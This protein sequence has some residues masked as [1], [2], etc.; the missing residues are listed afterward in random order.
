M[1][2]KELLVVIKKDNSGKMESENVS[3]ASN[4]SAN[5]PEK[6][7]SNPVTIVSTKEEIV[8]KVKEAATSEELQELEEIFS[9]SLTKSEIARLAKQDELLDLVLKEA[10]NRIKHNPGNLS[11]KDLLD[12]MNALQGNLDKIR[13]SR[14]SDESQVGPI[15]NVH[16]EVTVNMTGDGLNRD[17]QNKVMDLVSDLIRQAQQAEVLE[18][19]VTDVV[20]SDNIE[21]ISEEKGVDE[22]DD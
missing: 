11:T 15:T 1:K 2:E 12:Y 13:K 9:L 8:E 19:E 3:N 16:N 22:K 10:A 4:N 18:S 17:S 5:L 14:A 7:E 6:V 20:T 21:E